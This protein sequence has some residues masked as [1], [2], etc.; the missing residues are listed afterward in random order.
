MEWVKSSANVEFDH[1]KFT[2]AEVRPERS[3]SSMS[4]PL[5]RV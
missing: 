3:I 1:K 2:D 5:Q 4:I